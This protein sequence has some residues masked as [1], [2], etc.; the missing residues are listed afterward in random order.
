MSYGEK[1]NLILTYRGRDIVIS[2]SV[3][4]DYVWYSQV[5]LD[6]LWKEEIYFMLFRGASM[7]PRAEQIKSVQWLVNNVRFKGLMNVE[8]WDV[9]L[10]IFIPNWKGKLSEADCNKLKYFALIIETFVDHSGLL[11][12]LNVSDDGEY[13]SVWAANFMFNV[14]FGR[15]KHMIDTHESPPIHMSNL[16]SFEN[17]WNVSRADFPLIRDVIGALWRLIKKS[18]YA[19]VDAIRD[20]N[21]V[22][23]EHNFINSFPGWWCCDKTLEKFAI[24]CVECF[25]HFD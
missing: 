23:F 1:Y 9:M 11:L 25:A 18:A 4:A 3:D 12:N 16:V 8:W 15:K 10:D 21:D 6:L 24:I 2:S 13:I 20:L 5:W 22:R 7:W 14:I 17:R 19:N